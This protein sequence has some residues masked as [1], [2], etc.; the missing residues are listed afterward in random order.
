MD[1]GAQSLPTCR[2][3]FYQ[4]NCVSLLTGLPVA[5]ESGTLCLES[6]DMSSQLSC[7]FHFRPC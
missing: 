3:I 4:V 5:C 7:G 6:A 1:V 2:D